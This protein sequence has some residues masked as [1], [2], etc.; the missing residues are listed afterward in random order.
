MGCILG[1]LAKTPALVPWLLVYCSILGHHIHGVIIFKVTNIVVVCAG[2]AVC[3]GVLWLWV[4][5]PDR[6]CCAVLATLVDMV[7]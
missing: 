1:D 6:A 2:K 7:I 5:L 3:V 4:L